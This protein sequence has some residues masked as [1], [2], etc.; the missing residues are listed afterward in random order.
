MIRIIYRASSLLSLSLWI[1]LS[2][3]ARGQDAAPAPA[4][5]QGTMPFS[6]DSDTYQR[7]SKQIF[8]L[9]K[10]KLVKDPD[11]ELPPPFGVMV[12]TNWMD[13]DWKFESAAVSLANS[14][15][16]NLDAAANATM[17]L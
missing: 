8:P 6:S 7:P 5:A 11:R 16:I 2:S 4:P 13:S 17:D 9:F 10:E 3:V 12:L 1:L 14:P 15:Y